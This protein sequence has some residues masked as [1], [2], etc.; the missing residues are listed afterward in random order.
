MA[1]T[2]TDFDR[3]WDLDSEHVEEAEGLR[4]PD[5]LSDL[6]RAELPRSDLDRECEPYCHSSMLATF[7]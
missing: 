2:Y 4:M 7:L 1:T 6:T 5:L 3:E